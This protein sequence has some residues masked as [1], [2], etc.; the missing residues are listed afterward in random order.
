M[1]H[2]RNHKVDKR[3][4][5]TCLFDQVERISRSYSAAGSLGEP[6]SIV[7]YLGNAREG[8]QTPLLR[9]LLNVD[10]QRRRLN[11]ENP[12]AEDYLQ[13]FPN[14]ESII[15]QEFLASTD[16]SRTTH[17]LETR[18]TPTPVALRLGDYTLLSE[19]GRGGMGTVYE[20][21]HTEHKN[22]VALKLLPTVDAT[23]LHLFKREFRSL[24][25][26]NHRHLV[27]LH[28]LECDGDQWFFTMDLVEGCD[29]IEYVRDG[30]SLDEGRLR[31]ALAQLVS[32]V[33]AL[34]GNFVVHR[35][36]K[37]SNVMVDSDGKVV[38][39]DFG[40]ALEV[41]A[42]AKTQTLGGI[43]GTPAYMSPEQAAGKS[44]TAACDWY[45]VG[46]ILYQSL[47]GR[48]PFTGSPLEVM[49]AKQSESAPELS[50]SD[51]LP[52]DIVQLTM[53]LLASEAT[54]RPNALAIAQ[55]VAASQEAVTIS[56][57]SS[58]HLLIGRTAQLR[59]LNDALDAFS[60][61]NEPMTVFV[62]GRSGEG[63][64]TL[65]GAFLAPLEQNARYA[66]MQGRCY[67]R[68]SVPFKALD[69]AI[70]AL[71]GYL[72]SLPESEVPAMLP[73]EATVL[74]HVFPVF[75]RVDATAA[76][77]S[78]D[79]SNA[80]EQEIRTR[81]F[82]ALRELLGRIG[83][84]RRMILFID[85]LQWGDADSADALL[86]VLQPPHAPR[87]LLLGSYRSDEADDSPFLDAWE[88]G[89]S[90]RGIEITS[91]DV[92]VSPFSR[93]ECVEL[94]VTLL[95]QDTEHIRTRAKQFS[96]QTG[97]NPFLL[98]ELVGC[99]DPQSDSFRA[100]PVHEVIDEKLS[101][102]PTEA[103]R[104]LE[105]ISVSG[106]AIE[107]KECAAAA[108]HELVPIDTLSRM[109]SERLIRFLGSDSHRSLDTYHDRIRE[110][111]VDKLSD[112]WRQSLHRDLGET[113]EGRCGGL[114]PEQLAAIEAGHAELDDLPASHR[115]FDLSFHF[116][117][118]GMK[119]KAF[120][121][122]FLAA[123]QARRQF[124]LEVAARQY[125]LARRHFDHCGPAAR[126]RVLVGLGEVAMLTAQYKES[127]ACLLE[128]HTLSENDL[129]R[130]E[131]EVV[132]GELL[133]A[134]SRF[135]DSAERLA[136]T[137]RDIGVHVP[138]TLPGVIGGIAKEAIVQTFHT[139]LRYP[140]R[141]DCAA[142]PMDLV[143]NQLLHGLAMS[144]WFRSTPAIL[145]ATTKL[146][147]R[148]ERQ[149][150]SAEL[151]DAHS[152][153]GIVCCVGG[154]KSRG[155]RYLHRAD[156][157]IDDENL[158]SRF[159]NCFYQT[160]AAY[161]N[162]GFELCHEMVRRG[163]EI[164]SRRGDLWRAN[165]FHIH[166]TLAEYRLGN[167][168]A[169]MRKTQ[170]E[171]DRTNRMGDR[172]TSRDHL[173]LMAILTEGDIPYEPM[174][175]SLVPVPDNYQATNQELQAEARWHLFHGRTREG[176]E[177]ARQA[178]DL[179]MQHFVVNHITCTTF[180]LI[181]QAMR[182]HAATLSNQDAAE[183]DRLLRRGY[184]TARWLVRIGANLPDHPATLRE[185]ATY[186][187][188][189]GKLKKA[190]RT[191][192]HS[193][194]MTED[195]S[196]CYE[197][198]LNKLALAAYQLKLGIVDTAKVENARAAVE[199]FR[200]AVK[201]DAAVRPD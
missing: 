51:G 50:N 144:L 175:A 46:V 124:A 9:N 111:V 57:P 157:A 71:C 123:E 32:A 109:R 160:V 25:N 196:M 58:D 102:L 40:L 113:I 142:E 37:P 165:L 159:L 192:K 103:R 187:A 193:L 99:F 81:A 77:H 174:A 34:H 26:I 8:M 41:D 87:V 182:Q 61:S 98:T 16:A 106:Q 198:A 66:L 194:R 126:R 101:R 84:R 17:P 62:S 10:I 52:E 141:Q 122:S 47:A 115:L 3:V 95:Q 80:D 152:I 92:A 170:R 163:L 138:A 107:L 22:R 178:Y 190:I 1:K 158:A 161:T 121:Y 36:L 140:R 120:A 184:R 64:S 20:A 83:D 156:R 189:R 54:S 35:D 93:E 68:E 6:P 31:S 5:D 183:A 69:S 162:S 133:R 128:A 23:R 185:L 166:D 86:Q 125:R 59:E 167:L 147:N 79:L 110:T 67:D 199:Q 177:V 13:W 116:D 18:D 4:A 176:L 155:W 11:G 14:H 76:S 151:T 12:R 149:G 164:G 43:V 195:R 33:M 154:W 173:N 130:C 97:G 127:E 60:A 197:S 153:H 70:D 172:N 21:V 136:E 74:A 150:P 139:L 42:A 137:L 169:A 38:L 27:G 73:R 63:K 146:L 118:A 108:R 105:V 114:K 129:E 85:D 200:E 44:V 30:G 82:A 39:L 55:A 90:K 65:C 112:S 48:L 2:E 117:A 180:P 96:E 24:A 179:I 171:F 135:S 201:A 89:Q 28:S 131:V 75:R 15:R 100:I 143:T 145:W 49:Q 78:P 132:M 29:F 45:A 53:R 188:E 19:L 94:V 72:N 91:R 104:L 148:C 191:L 119:R 168:G 181:L 88:A 7:E 186:Q 134:D 56:V